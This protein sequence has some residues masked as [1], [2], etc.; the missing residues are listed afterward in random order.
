M[1]IASLPRRGKC[2][3]NFLIPTLTSSLLLRHGLLITGYTY[4]IAGL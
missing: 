3:I 4:E 1:S 2:A